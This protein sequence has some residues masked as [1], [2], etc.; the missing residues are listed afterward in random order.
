MI[1]YI[2]VFLLIEFFFVP[3]HANEQQKLI[4]TKTAVIFNTLCA[5]CH[6]GGCSGRLT[7]Y[8]N[9]KSAINHIKRYSGDLEFNEN[10]IK[11]FFIL[12]NYMKKECTLLMSN[13]DN[14][15]EYKNISSFALS[16]NKG[17]FIPLGNLKTG[18]YKLSFALKENISFRLEVISHNLNHYLDKSI[19]SHQKEYRFFF[20]V[21]ESVDGFLRILSKQPLHLVY[22]KLKKG[23]NDNEK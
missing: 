14:V 13:Y 21:N 10:E 5:K 11:E 22:L 4:S 20:T 8:D 2:Y 17:Y 6:E 19:C 3:L 23:K 1:K 12:L 18:E 9:Q 7:F 15:S 16:S